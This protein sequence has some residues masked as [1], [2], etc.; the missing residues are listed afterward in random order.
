MRVT[1]DLPDEDVAA[2]L[3]A[4]DADLDHVATEAVRL[5]T[6]LENFD[7]LAEVSEP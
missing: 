3:T 4:Y 5:A 6:R 2:L 7:E 1:L